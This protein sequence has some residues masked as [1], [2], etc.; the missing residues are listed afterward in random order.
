LTPQERSARIEEA[1]GEAAGLRRAV[2]MLENMTWREEDEAAARGAIGALRAAL[3][4]V[5]EEPRR[6]DGIPGNWQRTM[7][8][9]AC[10]KVWTEAKCQDCGAYAV[11]PM[12]AAPTAS[13]FPAIDEYLARAFPAPPAEQGC[14]GC[15]EERNNRERLLGDQKHRF[16]HICG[17]TGRAKP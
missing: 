2:T 10:H 16:A 3:A 13:T 1:E 8:C 17:G 5:A 11:H 12:P 14:E 9:G 4:V 15:I 7:E 6:S